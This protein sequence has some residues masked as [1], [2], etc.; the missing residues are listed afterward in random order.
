MNF[1]I[2][3]GLG[4][5]FA[6]AVWTI[7]DGEDMDEIRRKRI[8]RNLLQIELT[9]ATDALAHKMHVEAAGRAISR[10]LDQH[11]YHYHWLE[12]KHW[13]HISLWKNLWDGHIG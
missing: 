5:T 4:A 8:E 7:L 1:A 6:W 11:R 3:F 10:S 2:I 9:R 12:M 13:H